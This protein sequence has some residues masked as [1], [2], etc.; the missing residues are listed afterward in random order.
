MYYCFGPVC[1]CGLDLLLLAWILPI[2]IRLPRKHYPV[3][4]IYYIVHLQNERDINVTPEKS[5]IIFPCTPSMTERIMLAFARE[6]I[7]VLTKT[8]MFNTFSMTVY[9]RRIDYNQNYLGH[10]Q[11]FSL[12]LQYRS[13]TQC[14]AIL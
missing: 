9:I 12:R 3:H 13:N 11:V 5:R 14:P 8:E 10:A 4:L 2:L 7:S 1:F 6:R